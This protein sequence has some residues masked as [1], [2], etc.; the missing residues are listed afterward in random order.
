MAAEAASM[1]GAPEDAEPAEAPG[2]GHRSSPRSSQAPEPP[3]LREQAFPGLSWR[4]LVSGLPDEVGALAQDAAECPAR[5]ID[6]RLRA[7]IAFLQSVDFEQGRVL[8]QMQDRGLFAELG[9]ANLGE[10]ARERLGSSPRTARRLVAL[11]RTG[12]RAPAVASAFRRGQVH[13]LQAHALARVAGVETARAWVERAKQVSFRRLEEE[14]EERT[15]LAFWAP[16]SVAAF[17]LAMLRRAGS[18]ARLLAHAVRE[19]VR[20]GEQFRDHADFGRDGYRCTAP[21]CTQR[22]NLQS[23][24]IR[25]LG[26]GGPDVAWNRTTLCAWHHLRALHGLGTLRIAGRAPGGLVFELGPEG[27]GERF[28]SGDVRFPSR[29]AAG[30]R[31]A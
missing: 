18:L 7:A 17:F 28:A 21:G 9:F 23:H 29:A 20:R 19:W 16:K 27:Q 10:Y 30:R 15:G 13:A 31:R 11:A 2:P 24:H 26:R 4:A 25:F 1:V 5:E 22:R 3:A 8:R 12:H 6:R 14:V